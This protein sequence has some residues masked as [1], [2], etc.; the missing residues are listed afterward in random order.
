MGDGGE[1]MTKRFTCETKTQGSVSIDLMKDNG[2]IIE[3]FEA[4]NL[5]NEL[6][7]ENE[8]LQSE[9]GKLTDLLAS[10]IEKNARLLQEN[11]SLKIEN[12]RF[13]EEIKDLNDVLARYEE[14]ELQE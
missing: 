6:H 7:E 9:I 8:Q 10:E 4:I 5:L 1:R 14:K 12:M 11:N 13:K 3:K 2:Q